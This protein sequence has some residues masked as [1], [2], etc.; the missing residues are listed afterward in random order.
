MI[1]LALFC[2]LV[3]T[4]TYS[5]A[6][7][8]KEVPK[9]LVPFQGAWKLVKVEVGGKEPKDKPTE[10]VRFTFTGNKLTIK[11][12]KRNPDA[13]TY[14]IDSKKDPAEIDLVSSKDRKALG[15]YKFDKDGKLTMS[16]IMDP[17]APRPKKFGEAEAVQ[18]V[19]EKVKE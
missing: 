12:G 16:Y 3:L 4:A 9:E 13:G 2:G 7:D 18:V 5:T 19:L 17:N 6:D 10:E 14:S 15:I 8:K 1:R 11:E